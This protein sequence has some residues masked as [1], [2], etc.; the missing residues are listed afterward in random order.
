MFSFPEG[1]FA[2]K[3]CGLIPCGL[4]EGDHG[5]WHNAR[6]G[7]GVRVRTR[8]ADVVVR[9]LG[10][11]GPREVGPYRVLA[12]LGRGG[13]GRVLLGSGPDGRLVALKLVHE[14]FA[15]DDVFRARFR[16][17][18][19]ASRAVS[20]AYTAAV[21]DAD[22]DAPTPWLASVFVPGPSLQETITA[23]GALPEQAVLRLTAGL[24]T[25]LIQIHRAELVHRD[26]KPSNVLLAD[27]GPR[28]IDFGIVRAVG[29][30]R[31]G[32]LTRAG[33]LIGSPAFMSPEQAESEPVTPASDVFSLGSVVVAAC[34]GAS[35]FADT[36]TRQT[37]DNVVQADPDLSGM[38]TAI[39]RI[40][41]PCLAK[42]PANRPTPAELLETIG[43]IAPSARTWPA[44]VHQ[45]IT[46]RQA[47]VARI[48]DPVGESTAIVGDDAPT[49]TA[50]RVDTDPSSDPTGEPESGGEKS[51][52]R[53]ESAT[54]DRSTDRRTS[55]R[56]LRFGAAVSAVALA[57]VLVWSLWP[58]P[59]TSPAPSPQTAQTAV[60]SVPEPVRYMMFS[61]DGRILAT[62][63]SDGTVRLWDTRSYQQ[64]GQPI[65]RRIGFQENLRFSPDNRTLITASGV[66]EGEARVEWWDV[67]SGRQTGQPFTLE[68]SS[69][70]NRRTSIEWLGISGDGRTLIAGTRE[71]SV[72]LWDIVNRQRIGHYDNTTGAVISP[73]GHT[74]VTGE[75]TAG[76]LTL[77]DL[78][79]GQ[80]VGSP[81]NAPQ[82][83]EFNSYGFSPDGRM[84]IASTWKDGTTSV[85]LWDVSG[86]RQLRRTITIPGS[87]RALALGQNSFAVIGEDDTLRLWDVASGQQIR[88]A[89]DVNAVEFNPDGR[90]LAV[91]GK[92]DIVR[93]W[94]LPD[95]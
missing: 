64:V 67:A 23:I 40:V 94:S 85:R 73:D 3:I 58:P 39:R 43:N 41:E 11:S 89:S 7:P 27:D 50:T 10:A 86:S 21:V 20:G 49:V 59:P 48:L 76:T 71:N 61:P 24:A 45:L 12:E 70:S 92:D 83:A 82:G 13:M 6:Q 74:I 52:S 69:G 32:E 2:E 91:A 8:R 31:A 54:A 19:A 25:A 44:E 77:R 88:S 15:A 38:P 28:V 1:T 53:H 72:Q 79:S 17:E 90:T 42:N 63:G 68:T 34:T 16:A 5:W 56:R 47:E 65:D 95:S 35:P 18:V 9:P 55:R 14:Q 78:A 84:L 81:I 37:L 4:G 75:R 62:V 87:V 93:L 33:W 60:M 51:P 29:G 26:L 36:T 30:D 46:R 22:P 57:G 80:L 66:V